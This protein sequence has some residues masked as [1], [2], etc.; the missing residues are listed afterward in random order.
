MNFQL[1]E[2]GKP[3]ET[4]ATLNCKEACCSHDHDRHLGGI[5]HC[6]TKKEYE[7]HLNQRLPNNSFLPGA[8]KYELGFFLFLFVGGGRGDKKI[9]S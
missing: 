5:D 7:S 4:C 9:F 3:P 8:D 1:M 2:L 6:C